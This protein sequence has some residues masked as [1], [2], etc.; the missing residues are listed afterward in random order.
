MKNFTITSA[1]ILILFIS[2]AGCK[3]D[4]KN[5][6]INKNYL[7][8]GS[9]KCDL[10]KGILLKVPYDDTLNCMM[11]ELF[12]PGIIIHENLTWPDSLSGNGHTITFI[13]Y[14]TSGSDKLPPGEFT[15]SNPSDTYHSGTLLYPEYLLDWNIN[16]E[17][18]P[19]FC[20]VTSGTLKV[21]QNGAEYELSFKGKDMTNNTI[22]CYYKGAIKYYDYYG[23]KSVTKSN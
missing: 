4:S 15:V 6:E 17:P 5:E 21:I 12:S 11:L 19:A 13:M 23:D 20:F 8:V 16:Q 18:D 2:M 9:F 22:S 14:N 10:S 7:K 1:I 3:K